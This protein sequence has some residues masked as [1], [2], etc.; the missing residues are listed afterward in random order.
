MLH[1]LR[2]EEVECYI[3]CATTFYCATTARHEEGECLLH[4]LRHEEGE[5]LLH[6]LRHEEGECYIYCATKR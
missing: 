1:L 4:L 5:C 3:Y 2:H 6:L